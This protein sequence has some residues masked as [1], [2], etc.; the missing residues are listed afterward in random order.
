MDRL[1]CDQEYVYERYAHNDRNICRCDLV[2]TRFH[3]RRMELRLS[4]PLSKGVILS[5]KESDVD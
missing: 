5:S 2:N 1:E 3:S 4:L